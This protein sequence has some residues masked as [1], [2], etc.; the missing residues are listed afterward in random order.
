M[1]PW[2]TGFCFDPYLIQAISLAQKLH[3]NILGVNSGL[4]DNPLQIKERYKEHLHNTDVTLYCIYEN[5]AVGPGMAGIADIHK[6]VR[7]AGELKTVFPDVT[8]D[9]IILEDAFSEPMELPWL[10]AVLAERL[11]NT[12]NFALRLTEQ[13]A[14]PVQKMY[15]KFQYCKG[16]SGIWMIGRAQEIV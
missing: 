11:E 5:Q 7:S 1:D 14:A 16:I 10:L 6:R 9:H 2:G 12:G 3:I 4:G 13:E 8:F 15:P